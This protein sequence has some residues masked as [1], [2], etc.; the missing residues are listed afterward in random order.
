MQG[1]NPVILAGNDSI[2]GNSFADAIAGFTGNDKLYGRGGNDYV[3]GDAGNDILNGGNGNDRLAGGSGADRFVFN[4]ALGI[5]NRDVVTDFTKQTDLIVLDDD[6]FT[7]LFGTSGGAGLNSFNYRVGQAADGNDFL[8][9]N[10]FTDTLSYDDDGVG[11]R[12]AIPFATITLPGTTA[13]AYTDFLI[14][15]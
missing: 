9:Y 5:D 10:T 15:A 14:I 8:L 11:P 3:Q 2:Y 12:A 7:R 1:G 4:S 6:I 13:P